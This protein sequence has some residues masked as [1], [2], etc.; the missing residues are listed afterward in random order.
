MSKRRGIFFVSQ[1]NRGD[2]IRWREKETRKRYQ[3]FCSIFRYVLYGTGA[4]VVL[5]CLKGVVSSV[6]TIKENA[7]G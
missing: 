6:D 4:G 7:E 1:L 5:A 2:S 3:G